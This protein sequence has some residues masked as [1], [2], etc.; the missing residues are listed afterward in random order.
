MSPAPV[1]QCTLYSIQVLTAMIVRGMKWSK[2][3]LTM[4]KKLSNTITYKD[5]GYLWSAAT[6]LKEDRETYTRDYVMKMF[7][8]AVEASWSY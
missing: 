2:E 5:M 6:P 1:Y 7:R 8:R 3:L 4:F